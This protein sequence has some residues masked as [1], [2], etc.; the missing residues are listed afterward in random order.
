MTNH[1]LFGVPYSQT[2][3]NE[4]LF[5]TENLCCDTACEEDLTIQMVQFETPLSPAMCK[6][7]ILHLSFGHGVYKPFMEIWG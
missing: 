5:E 7:S 1:Q 4:G 3:P 2:H 6:K